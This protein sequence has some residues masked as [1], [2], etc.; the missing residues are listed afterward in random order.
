MVKKT[1][2]PWDF[3]DEDFASDE[4]EMEAYGEDEEV[5]FAEDD[6]DDPLTGKREDSDPES[7]ESARR[8]LEDYLEARRLRQELGEGAFSDAD[9]QEIY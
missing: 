8:R 2:K 7:R 4:E 5:D 3:E 1:N 6:L 9:L